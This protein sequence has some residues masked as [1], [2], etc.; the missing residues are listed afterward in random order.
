MR[1]RTGTPPKTPGEPPEAAAH[2]KVWDGVPLCGEIG[3]LK[4]FKSI[5]MKKS[6]TL[7][8][9]RLSPICRVAGKANAKNKEPNAPKCDII[10]F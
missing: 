5:Y 6:G 4:D 7:F 1:N 3:S 9:S 8:S 2:G 10:I